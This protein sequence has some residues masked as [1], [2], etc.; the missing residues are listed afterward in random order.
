M[1]KVNDRLPHIDLW[2][3]QFSEAHAEHQELIAFDVV[4]ASAGKMII[5]LGVTSPFTQTCTQQH[6]PGYLELASHFKTLGV[7]EIW[8]VSVNDAYVMA[9]WGESLGV[10]GQ[11]RMLADGCAEFN[12][13]LGLT[14]DMSSRGMGVRS[15]RYSMVVV[16]GEIKILNVEPEG[17][18]VV[19]DAQQLHLQLQGLL[20]KV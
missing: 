9:A 3:L 2:E 19:S 12:K 1:I 4:Q 16:D 6:L 5:L 14:R 17:K 11:I 15:Q 8:C 10:S 18:Y 7:D 13:A 20:D